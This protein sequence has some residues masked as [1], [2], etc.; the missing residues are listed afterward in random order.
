[1][2]HEQAVGS[3]DDYYD[4][5]LLVMLNLWPAASWRYDSMLPGK[6]RG[7]VSFVVESHLTTRQDIM[8]AQPPP[9]KSCSYPDLHPV[10]GHC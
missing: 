2:Q 9:D 10:R 5:A 8:K 7:V 4:A 3:T 1:V 6:L